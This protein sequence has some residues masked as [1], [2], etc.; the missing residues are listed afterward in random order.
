M[1]VDTIELEFL[2]FFSNSMVDT[3]NFVYML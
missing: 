1:Q 3:R 2:E